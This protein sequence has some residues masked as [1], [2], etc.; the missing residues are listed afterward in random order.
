MDSEPPPA[1]LTRTGCFES[2]WG[3]VESVPD[4]S[5]WISSLRN[6][7]LNLVIEDPEYAGAVFLVPNVGL[8]SCNVSA[9]YDETIWPQGD[10]AQRVRE[11]ML[12][13]AGDKGRS[14]MMNHILPGLEASAAER[15]V[16]YPTL[17]ADAVLLAGLPPSESDELATEIRFVGSDQVAVMDGL[18][19]LDGL[20]GLDGLD[21]LGAP[22]GNGWGHLNATIVDER[23]LC[24]PQK[25]HVYVL[26][27][28]LFPAGSIPSV[29]PTVLPQLQGYCEDS[30]YPTLKREG[31]FRPE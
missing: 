18:D 30:L 2:L 28:A 11:L 22:G 13:L 19:G 31:N 29:S 6:S 21:G 1:G 26:D 24:D 7:G 10:C 14:S 12:Y 8:A 9:V 23:A 3:A 27:R 5:S 4:A 15:G 20:E 17:L 16:G 25:G